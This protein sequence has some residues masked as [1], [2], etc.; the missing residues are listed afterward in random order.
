M[1]ILANHAKANNLVIIAA[2]CVGVV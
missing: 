2:P 1:E